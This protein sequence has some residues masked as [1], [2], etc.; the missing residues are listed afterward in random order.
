MIG[1]NACNQAPIWDGLFVVSH[2][3]RKLNTP[4]AAEYATKVPILNDIFQKL[5]GQQ[6]PHIFTFT[7]P[8]ANNASYL[9]GKDGVHAKMVCIPHIMV[10]HSLHL[11]CTV[12]S[13]ITWPINSTQ[14]QRR[15]SC[16]PSQRRQ[17]SQPAEEWACD[18]HQAHGGGGGGWNR[19]QPSP[20]GAEV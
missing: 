8:V 9:I 5:V 1:S 12:L 16:S 15:P 3:I 17:R 2:M 4:N 20:G 19:A 10:M 6:H 13:A 14:L 18:H 11:W 7:Q